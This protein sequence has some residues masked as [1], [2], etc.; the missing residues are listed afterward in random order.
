MGATAVLE[1]AAEMPPAKKSLANEIACS[2]MVLWSWCEFKNEKYEGSPHCP[3]QLMAC[4][5]E[6]ADFQAA[7]EIY[8][9][10]SIAIHRGNCGVS[11]LADA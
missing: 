10:P 5:D 4:T 2:L 11:G 9:T 3:L 1:M 7:L 6:M 8:V